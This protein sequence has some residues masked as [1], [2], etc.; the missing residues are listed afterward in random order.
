MQEN[1]FQ[2]VLQAIALGSKASFMFKPSIEEIKS[3]V[4]KERGVKAATLENVDLGLEEEQRVS[5]ILVK[6]ELAKPLSERSCEGDASETG[7]IK[8][9]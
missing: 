3:Y 8:F 5:K 6:E 1:G 7:L 9:F 2:E 4:A